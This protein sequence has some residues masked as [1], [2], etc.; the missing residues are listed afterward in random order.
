MDKDRSGTRVEVL[1]CKKAKFEEMRKDLKSM[2]WVRLFSGKDVIGKW[3]AFKGEI[4]RVQS[5][6]VPVRIK[7]KVNKKKEPWFSRDIGNL[8]KKKREIYDRY[9]QQGANKVLEDYNKCKKILK[10]EIRRAKRRREVALAVKVKDNPKSFYR[11]IKSKR[12]VRDKIGPL[13][14]QSG[15]LCMEPQEMGE[16]LNGFFASVF[17]KE[18]GKKSMEI[19]QINREVMELIQIKE[20]EVLAILRQIR[21]DKSPG[22]DRVFLR[23]LK[24]TKVEIAGALA[25]IFKMLV[26]EDWRIS[27][28]VTL[29]KKGSK[30]NLGNYRLVN[31]TSVLDKLLEGVLRLIR[32]SQRGFVRA[33]SCLTNL[34]EFFEEVTRKVDEGKAVDVVYMDF[35]KAFD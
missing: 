28:V 3:E 8:I 23:T 19:R 17:T 30:S 16:I 20:E 11:Y 35:S 9:R 18:T 22:P 25:D 13:E 27:H 6:Y 21:V 7:G 14:D 12:T 2:D 5:L 26:P 32:E 24:E 4:L 29:F 10:K 34:L 33:R 15:R 1:S 31:L